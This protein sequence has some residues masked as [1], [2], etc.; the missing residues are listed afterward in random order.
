[1]LTYLRLCHHRLNSTGVISS[2][3]VSIGTDLSGRQLTTLDKSLITSCTSL[4]ALIVSPFAGVLG[5]K[6]GRRPVIL[7]ADAL[8][9]LGALWQAA[10]SNVWSMILG[11]SLIGLG[12]GAASLITPLYVILQEDL[13]SLTLDIFPSCYRYM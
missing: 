4:F 3:L 13:V 9:I 10:S 12:V 11:R 1:M 7:I 8:F 5:D 2:T 6:L